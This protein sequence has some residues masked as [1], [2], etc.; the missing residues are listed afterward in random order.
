MTIKIP[1]N[2]FLALFCLLLINISVAN[3]SSVRAVWMY[4]FSVL[5][6]AS[7]ISKLT[8]LDINRVYLG[9][10]AKKLLPSGERASLDYTNKLKDFISLATANNIE[11]HAMTLMGNTFFLNSKHARSEQYIRWLTDYQSDATINE[12]FSGIHLDTE[13]HTLSQ[14]KTAKKHGDWAT[15]EGLMA[16]Y[17]SLLS[18]LEPIIHDAD[19]D[20][21][22]SAALHWKYNERADQGLVPSGDAQVLSRYLD[23]LVLMVYSTDSIFKIQE[24]SED[25]FNEANTVVGIDAKSFENYSETVYVQRTLDHH[26]RRNNKYLGTAVHYFSTFYK[27]YQEE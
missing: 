4:N 1:L 27:K 2:K 16:Q 14:W 10:S 8:E 3:A 5:D 15:V 25:E 11:I 13:P 21:D 26:N 12:K 9:V 20:L 18:K 24:R 23:T 7:T 6:N 19:S 22:F 17:V